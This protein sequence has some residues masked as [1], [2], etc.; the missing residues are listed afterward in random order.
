MT[1]MQIHNWL[2]GL[3]AI[4]IV[5]ALVSTFWWLLPNRWA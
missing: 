2:L 1:A 3:T 5:S 4:V